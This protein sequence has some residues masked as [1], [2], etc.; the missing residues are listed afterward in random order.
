MLLHGLRVVRETD[1]A[2]TV[3]DK[4]GTLG[5]VVR[6][7]APRSEGAGVVR[8]F[9]AFGEDFGSLGEAVAEFA[10]IPHAQLFDEKGD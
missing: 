10:K 3:R 1:E 6:V 8:S 7:E 9:R 4:K 2:Y 5:G